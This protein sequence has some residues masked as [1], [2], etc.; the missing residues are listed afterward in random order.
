[1]TPIRSP[2]VEKGIIF[3]LYSSENDTDSTRLQMEISGS[4]GMSGVVL[5]IEVETLP[6]YLVPCLF[7]QYS[8]CRSYLRVDMCV[9]LPS[10]AVVLVPVYWCYDPFVI[11][12]AVLSSV[13][14][15]F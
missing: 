5:D 15:Y 1:M 7:L 3:S 2:A 4:Q 8:T 12:G 6:V 14:G 10:T 9:F 13:P 11:I